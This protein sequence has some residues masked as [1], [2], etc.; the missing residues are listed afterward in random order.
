MLTPRL[1]LRGP[2]VGVLVGAC[3]TLHVSVAWADAPGFDDHLSCAGASCEV[4]ARSTGSGSAVSGPATSSVLHQGERGEDQNAGSSCV[5]PDVEFIR[6]GREGPVQMPWGRARCSATA[7]SASAG[8]EDPVVIDPVVL[9]EQARAAMSL[10]HPQIGTAPP[11]DKPRFVNMAS[12]MWVDAADWEPVSATASIS[13]GSVTVIATPERVLW[14]TGDGHQ[15][16][17]EGPGTEY[18]PAIYREEGSPDCGHTYTTLPPGGAGADV[19]LSAVWEWAIS[20]ST[21]TGDGGDL[22]DLSTSSTVA[23]PVSEIHSVVTHTG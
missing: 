8:E 14:D 21:S 1:L 7:F 22:E 5:M 10:P 6:S 17:C 12:W 9:A 23:V 11:L 18:S 13:A 15:V 4:V 3:W 16:V 19:E 20:W 2:L